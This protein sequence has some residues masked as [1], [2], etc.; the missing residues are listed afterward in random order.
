ML[1][2]GHKIELDIRVD[3]ELFQAVTLLE[4]IVKPQDQYLNS[5]GKLTV[6]NGGKGA[7]MNFCLLKKNFLA[8]QLALMAKGGKGGTQSRDL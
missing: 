2:K 1:T 3:P 8:K 7:A 6:G 5:R 4:R